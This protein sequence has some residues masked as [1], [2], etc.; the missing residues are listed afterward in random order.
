M[1]DSHIIRKSRHLSEY[2]EHPNAYIPNIRMGFG[3]FEDER[4]QAD[5]LAYLYAEFP[6]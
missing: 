2:L 5:V 4:K 6:H 3:G 1:K